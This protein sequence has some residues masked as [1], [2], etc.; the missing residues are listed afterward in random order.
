M[1]NWWNR[2]TRRLEGAVPVMAYEFKSH[3]LHHKQIIKLL[4]FLE[5]E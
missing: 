4:N 2:Q 1:Q 3:I 5:K